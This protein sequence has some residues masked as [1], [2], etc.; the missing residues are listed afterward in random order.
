MLTPQGYRFSAV[1]LCPSAA[2]ITFSRK[3]GGKGGEGVYKAI[4]M[5]VEIRINNSYSINHKLFKISHIICL[6]FRQTFSM[7][8]IPLFLAPVCKP[9]PENRCPRLIEYILEPVS[10]ESYRKEPK[11]EQI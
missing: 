11:R 7:N 9:V 2:M 4:V 10:V 8:A 5:Q 3:K 1:S 6:I